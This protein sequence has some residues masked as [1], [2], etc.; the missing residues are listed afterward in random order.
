[1]SDP[2]DIC[3]ALAVLYEFAIDDNQRKNL[4]QYFTPLQVAKD[5]IYL[6]ALE[7][8]DTVL[9]PGCGTGIFPITI[10]K[11]FSERHEDAALLQYLG[12]ENDP[13]LALSAAVSLDWVDAPN[14]WRI[15]YANFLAVE[16]K[17]LK[18]YDYPP[19]V[20]A[21]VANPPFVRSR[22]LGERNSLMNSLSLSG[23]SGLHSFFLAHSAKLL[24]RN[25]GRMVFIVPVEMKQTRYGSNLLERLKSD[26]EVIFKGVY[27]NREN[28]IWSVLDIEKVTFEKC[29][30]QVMTL[31]FFQS[32]VD[33]R[34]LP[35]GKSKRDVIVPLVSFA[36]V[37]RGISTGANSFFVLTDEEVKEVEIPKDFLKKVIPTKIPLPIV[38]EPKDW[39]ECKRAG[40]P[41]WLLSLP[42]RIP[43][44]DLPTTL[45]QYIKKGESR[46]IHLIPTCRNRQPWYHIKIPRVPDLVFTYMFRQYPKFV[47]NKAQAYNLTNLLSVYLNVPVERADDTM[48][49]VTELL[50]SELKKWIDQEPVG[51]RYRGG[52][53]K[54][55]PRDLWVMPVSESALGKMEIGLS[56]LV[57]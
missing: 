20:N 10:L 42:S 11:E 18:S 34:P 17:D 40:K 7:C 36:S 50:N 27:Y 52:L 15:L 53:V 38:F 12:I 25:G 19:K 9:D 47:Y 23:Y 30:H 1:V 14:T 31:V 13:L 6:L 54:F 22:K 56:R 24:E 33:G 8:G 37:H 44:E 4:G 21:I 39:E 48:M 45:R 2:Y 28:R 51:R 26:F 41:C 46:G 29:M 55:E 57:L 5:A 49:T 35:R 3:S 32:G 16:S 43:F